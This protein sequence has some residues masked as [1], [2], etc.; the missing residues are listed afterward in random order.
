[1][2]LEL[3]VAA[4]KAAG[5]GMVMPGATGEADGSVAVILGR[6][7]NTNRARGLA[8]S[9]DVTPFETTAELALATKR[10]PP[11]AVSRGSGSVNLALAAALRCGLSEVGVRSIEEE[12]WVGNTEMAS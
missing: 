6:F 9:E 3:V 5:E 12:A 11:S 2:A 1:M 10:A 4:A 7:A 8:S